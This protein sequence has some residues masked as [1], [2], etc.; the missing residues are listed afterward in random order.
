MIHPPVD[1]YLVVSR[2]GAIMNQVTMNFLIQA[3]FFFFN[4]Y[5][6]FS[7]VKTWEWREFPRG[8]PVVGTLHFHC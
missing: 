2:F 5:F 1:K 4:M 8:G 3:L 6:Y 7:W